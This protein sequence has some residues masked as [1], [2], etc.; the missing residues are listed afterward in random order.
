MRPQGDRDFNRLRVRL[1]RLEII[2]CDL[3]VDPLTIKGIFLTHEHQY[4]TMALK[5]K[6]PFPQR[7]GITVYATGEFWGATKNSIGCL[8][9]HLSRR[10]PRS[11]NLRVG[12][13]MV[14]PFVKPHDAVDPVFLIR[15]QQTQVGV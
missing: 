10:I 14:S 5:I 15:S 9:G 12:E 13:F 6:T 4:H 11:G 2:L 8:D 3:Q 1:R 7:Y